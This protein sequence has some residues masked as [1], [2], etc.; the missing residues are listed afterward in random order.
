M[1]YLSITVIITLY[2]E[3]KTPQLQDTGGAMLHSPTT[4]CQRQMFQFTI[5]YFND[6]EARCSDRALLHIE[7]LWNLTFNA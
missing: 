6:T 3:G 4:M 1:L 2:N 7:A 5:N